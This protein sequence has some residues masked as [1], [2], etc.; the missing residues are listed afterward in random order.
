MMTSFVFTGILSYDFIL[1]CR[2]FPR[3]LVETETTLRGRR[4]EVRAGVGER[5]ADPARRSGPA[6]RV[7]RPDVSSLRVLPAGDP[8]HQD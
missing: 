8:Q 7:P 6:R 2:H 4:G 1:N 5:S 3:Y